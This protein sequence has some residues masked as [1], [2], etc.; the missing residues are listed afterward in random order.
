MVRTIVLILLL[1]VLVACEDVADE[2]TTTDSSPTEIL[3][4]VVATPTEGLPALSAEECS[5]L[6]TAEGYFGTLNDALSE[7]SELLLEPDLL[8]DEWVFDVAAQLAIMRVTADDVVALMPPPALTDVHEL[9]DSAANDLHQATILI[10]QS[11]DNLDVDMML[12]ANELM[13]SGGTE[14]GEATSELVA[15]GVTRSGSC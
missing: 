7:L 6:A 15:F 11:I 8:S 3:E 13:A 4:E 1:T 14:I 9:Y 5:Y 12:E 10:A 2:S